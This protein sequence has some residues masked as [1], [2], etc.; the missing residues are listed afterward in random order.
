MCRDVILTFISDFWRSSGTC[1]KVDVNRGGTYFG[2]YTIMYYYERAKINLV[3]PVYAQL[4]NGSKILISE[5]S[6]SISV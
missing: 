6:S 4:A 2:T 3:F 1:T 5:R